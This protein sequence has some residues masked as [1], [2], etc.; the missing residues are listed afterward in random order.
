MELYTV[1][2]LQAILSTA[3]SSSHTLLC[4]TYS[5]T[6]RKRNSDTRVSVFLEQWTVPFALNR[7]VQILCHI[8]AE[9]I[10]SAY[11]NPV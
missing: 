6:C 8:F 9:G 3:L 7:V 10:S 11:A 5:E 4:E 2:K 1:C